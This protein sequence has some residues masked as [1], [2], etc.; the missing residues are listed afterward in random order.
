VLRLLDRALA[1]HGRDVGYSTRVWRQDIIL[2]GAT[3]CGMLDQPDADP[4]P[5]PATIDRA[6]RAI[7]DAIPALTRDRIEVPA[8][9]THAAGD[10]LLVYAAA[11]DPPPD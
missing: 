8:A 4:Y 9:L 11:S 1:A 6:A 3:A 7:A 10:L 5:L 2:G